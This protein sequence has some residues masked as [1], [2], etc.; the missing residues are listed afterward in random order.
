M[1]DA[2]ENDVNGIM[3][4]HIDCLQSV[5][6]THYTKDQVQKWVNAQSR[7]EYS[8]WIKVAA[9]FLVV[10]DKD[11]NIIAFAYI[12]K[13]SQE[14][15]SPNMDYEVHKLYVSPAAGRRGI[16]RKLLEEL[17]RRVRND[18]GTGIAIKSSMNAVQFYKACGY[19]WM[20]VDNVVRV[21]E[22]LLE[23]KHMEKL[24]SLPDR[25]L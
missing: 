20:G 9:H 17:E 25:I 19:R 14:K 11:D 5:C 3:Q 6:S 4:V 13:C 2:Q 18:G 24:I 16:G 7:S 22:A 21:G 1:R 15:F 10:A 12:G 23:C 8:S